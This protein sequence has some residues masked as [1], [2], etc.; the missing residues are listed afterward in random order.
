[1]EGKVVLV[2]GAN[3]GL[4]RDVTKAFLDAGAVV[5]GVARAIQQSEF[6]NPNFHPVA[7]DLSTL[8]VARQVVDGITAEIGKLDVLVHTVGGF[9]GGQTIA[10]TDDATFQRIA[11]AAKDGCPV[12]RA[13]K[14]NV[15][16]QVAAKLQ[17][18]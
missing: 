14:G 10:E 8:A 17:A 3:G 18:A 4:G 11:A 7:A 2:T 16:I 6:R 5:A 9:A 13:L 12:S 15:D 1:M